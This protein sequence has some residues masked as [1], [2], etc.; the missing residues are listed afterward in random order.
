MVT[1]VPFPVHLRWRDRVFV[2]EKP[3]LDVAA[4][5]GVAE[6]I[7]KEEPVEEQNIFRHVIIVIM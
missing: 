3:G 6:A 2:V 5:G 1:V 4:I 7:D